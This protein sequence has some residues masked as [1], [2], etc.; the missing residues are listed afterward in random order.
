MANSKILLNLPDIK[1]E[2]DYETKLYK[3]HSIQANGKIKFKCITTKND[4]TQVTRH[5]NKT[6]FKNKS[7]YFIDVNRRYVSIT[8]VIK[9]FLNRFKLDKPSFLAL[10]CPKCKTPLKYLFRD[11][12]N[13]VYDYI[14]P[15]TGKGKG[16][17]YIEREY[18][19]E[20]L[21]NY[22][23]A[24][25]PSCQYTTSD[26]KKM[27]KARKHRRVVSGKNYLIDN[28]DHIDCLVYRIDQEE[29]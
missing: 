17:Y 26:I 21:G 29:K 27:V 9:S 23:Y 19:P 14:D 16:D 11:S 5:T 18:G 1:V 12:V 22:D 25:C 20:E 2:F 6:I 13:G 28:E 3:F 7:G 8:P 15:T 10:T 24:Y 4:G